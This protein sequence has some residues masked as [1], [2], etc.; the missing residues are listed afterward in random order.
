MGCWEEPRYL[1]HGRSPGIDVSTVPC[2]TPVVVALGSNQGDSFNILD[3]A[4]MRLKEAFPSGFRS[5]S[6]WRSRP[7]HCPAGSPDFIN[8]IVA[9]DVP[10]GMSP[11]VM[12]DFL[13]TI[14]LEN[15]RHRGPLMNAPRT[16]DLDLVL[17]GD[18]I[19]NE[20]SLILPHPRAVERRFVMEP[21][22]ELLPGLI[23]PCTRETVENLAEGLRRTDQ[24]CERVLR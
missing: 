2:K 5:S 7:V 13:Q 16:L 12:L 19:L 14:E 11:R 15:G 8:G 6:Y 21:L 1:F 17:F 10:T 3:R 24:T 9:F 23:F 4:K 18:V 20:T 22:A